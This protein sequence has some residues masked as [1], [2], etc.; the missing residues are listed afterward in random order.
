MVGLTWLYT[1]SVIAT[2]EWPSISLT[3]R[4]G[5]LTGAE[6][7]PRTPAQLHRWLRTVLRNQAA[8]AFRSMHGTTVLSYDVLNDAR[9]PGTSE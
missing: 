3:E 4:V 5:D 6:T 2:V 1:S 8:R 9:N 7:S